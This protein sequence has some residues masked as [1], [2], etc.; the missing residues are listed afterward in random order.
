MELLVSNGIT[1]LQRKIM[2]HRIQKKK[3][4]R[5]LLTKYPDCKYEYKISDLIITTPY[6]YEYIL[7]SSGGRHPYLCLD[8]EIDYCDW[9]ILRERHYLPVHTYEAL[10]FA[11][12]LKGSRNKKALQIL[13]AARLEKQVKDNDKFAHSPP[14]RSWLNKILDKYSLKLLYSKEIDPSK[15]YEATH[16]KIRAFFDIFGNFISSFPPELIFNADESMIDLKQYNKVVCSLH[17]LNTAKNKTILEAMEQHIP[18]ISGMFCFSAVGTVVKPMIIIPYQN[19]FTPD[20]HEIISR[21]EC[22]LFSSNT[23]WETKDTFFLWAVC[24]CIWVNQFRS[25]LPNPQLRTHPILLILDG[26]SSRKDLPSLQ[27]FNAFKIIVLILPSNVTHLLQPFDIGIAAVFKKNI[28]IMFSQLKTMDRTIFET[29]TTFYRYICIESCIRAW[30][31]SA[32]PE[33]CKTSFRISGLFPTDIEKV[34]EGKYITD[35]EFLVN[36]IALRSKKIRQLFRINSRILTNEDFIEN[37]KTNLNKNYLDNVIEFNNAEEF[38]TQISS[39]IRLKSKLIHIFTQFPLFIYRKEDPIQIKCQYG[40]HSIDRFIP[41][42]DAQNN[43]IENYSQFL[44]PSKITVIPALSDYVQI[45]TEIK[46]GKNFDMLKVAS[47]DFSNIYCLKKIKFQFIDT[48]QSIILNQAGK[49]CHL[50]STYSEELI[51]ILYI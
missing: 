26:H 12:K 49:I 10:D 6:G 40:C 43:D 46:K 50:H 9:I 27:L 23:G 35:E 36:H 38:L 34:F 2:K 4:L 39:L 31:S 30:N 37:M 1:Q 13:I 41:I 25:E 14:S 47:R 8:D 11:V 51:K 16:Q 45:I 24:F 44:H 21:N 28:K 20:I 29:E 48:F 18:H 33:L 3:T 7:N 19:S 5:E 22:W 42:S 32:S 17:E 15:I